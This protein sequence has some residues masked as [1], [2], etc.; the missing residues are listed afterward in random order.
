MYASLSP[1]ELL[2]FLLQVSTLLAA[3]LLLGRLAARAGLPT[4]AGELCAGIVLG[5]SL[6][7]HSALHLRGWMVPATPSQSHLI[8]AVGQIGVLLLV[9][10]S[11][12]QLDFGLIRR[13]T[14]T[15]IQVGGASLI[16]PLALGAGAGLLLPAVLIGHSGDRGTFAFFFGVAMAVSA[17]PVI[18]KMLLDLDLLHRNIGQLTLA[19]SLIDDAAGWLLLSVASAFV[20]MQ[21]TQR[22]WHISLTLASLVGVI[23][24][25]AVLGRPL[26][27]LLLRWL[28]QSADPAVHTAAVVALILLAAAGTD[29]LGLE[30]VFG[31]FT[32]GVVIAS[33]DGFDRARL[34]P[35]GT[36]VMGGLAP[37][38]F[39]TAGLRLSMG[40][41]LSPALLTA[42][43][44][45]L[46]V[47]IAGKFG[48]AYAGARLSR[49]SR[50]EAVALGAGLNAR[51]V[52]QIVIATVGLSINVLTAD[53][54]T[55]IVLVAVATS[56]MA[57]P[58]LRTAMR[59]TDLTE[60]EE[61]R[62][63]TLAV[64]G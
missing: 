21:A 25:A 6:L 43:A 53:S 1:H 38:F 5:P 24:G 18:A 10:L 15:V 46:L 33:V 27:R 29:A 60:E 31:A 61:L 8:D 52:I 50:R 55:I 49:L 26:V 56:V 40:V 39:A 36:V 54:Y 58:V 12:M 9:G 45:V 44:G 28:N 63:M 19:A 14:R 23:L 37:V 64:R 42:T 2:T 34:A 41:L 3:A 22:A 57:A 11:G 30:P 51:G 35:L 59:R 48:G 47:A 4:V 16:L 13:E 20:T 7:G 17:I 62:A 32:C